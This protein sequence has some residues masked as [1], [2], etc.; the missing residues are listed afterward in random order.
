VWEGKWKG[1]GCSLSPAGCLC[2]RAQVVR[3]GVCDQ[4]YT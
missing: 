1:H 3:G 2:Q 4:L